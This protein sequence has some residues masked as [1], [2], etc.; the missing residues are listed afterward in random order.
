[1]VSVCFCETNY[2]T[3]KLSVVCDRNINLMMHFTDRIALNNMTV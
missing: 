2:K 1:M 3:M